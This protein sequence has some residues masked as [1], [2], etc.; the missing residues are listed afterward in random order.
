MNREETSRTKKLLEQ[1][2]APP[3]LQ[4]PREVFTQPK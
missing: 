4:T 1:G 2:L 3:E